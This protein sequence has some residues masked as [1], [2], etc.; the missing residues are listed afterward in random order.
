MLFLRSILAQLLEQNKHAFS[1]CASVYRDK[2]KENLA[3]EMEDYERILES[4]ATHGLPVTCIV[5]A[6]DESE[7]GTTGPLRLRQHVIGLLTRLVDA[8]GSQVRFIVLSRYT[9]DIDQGFRHWVRQGG[10]LSH[11]ILEQENVGDV[12]RLVD[13]G[14]AV[15]KSA[16]NAFDSD[17][18][19]DM[20]DQDPD[21][22]SPKIHGR[23]ETDHQIFNRISQT[24]RG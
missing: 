23:Q 22:L 13:N 6:L 3:W 24:H 20:E 18:D 2:K 14:L 8:P 21:Y 9:V 17:S 16:M 19:D 5:D 7:D 11:I 1:L 12:A 15:L 4:L 10:K